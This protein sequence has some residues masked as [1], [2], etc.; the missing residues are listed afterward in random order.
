MRSL[1]LSTK[2]GAPIPGF[3]VDECVYVNG[4]EIDYEVEWLGRIGKPTKDVSAL[5]GQ[6]VRLVA[7]CAGRACMRCSLWRDERLSDRR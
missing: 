1:V 6:T 5:A 4:D 2:S 3:S 7:R